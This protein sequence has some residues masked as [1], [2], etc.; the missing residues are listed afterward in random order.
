MEAASLISEATWKQLRTARGNAETE[1]AELLAS[2]REDA[3][4]I[5]KTALADLPKLLEA[6]KIPPAEVQ[7][8]LSVPL[9]T[10]LAGLD[11]EKD[12]TRVASLPERAAR[13][14][15]ELLAAVQAERQRRTPKPKP[16]EPK[17]PV[18]QVSVATIASSV[19]IENE[20]QWNL[21]RDKLDAAVKQELQNGNEVELL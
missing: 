21:V 4:S 10:F 9:N 1:L 7:E 2:W 13:L 16:G 6:H 18:K 5:A 14:A 19:R 20:V 12:V 17:K 8:T 15:K 11:A 3:R